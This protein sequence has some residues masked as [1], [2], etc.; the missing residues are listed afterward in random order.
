MVQVVP[1][2]TATVT[3]QSAVGNEGATVVVAPEIAGLPLSFDDVHEP[4]Y[5]TVCAIQYLNVRGGPGTMW[6]VLYQL[7]RGARVRAR[8]WFDGWVMIKAAEWVKGDFLCEE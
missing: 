4:V 5:L 2:P 3:A 7:E 6:S 8:E 1:L